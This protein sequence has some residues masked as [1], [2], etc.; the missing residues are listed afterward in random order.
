MSVLPVLLLLLQAVIS[1]H[2]EL[3]VVPAVVT[4]AHG[5]L[6]SGLTQDNFR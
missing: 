1:V 5:Q 3:V 4:D 6:V 2:T